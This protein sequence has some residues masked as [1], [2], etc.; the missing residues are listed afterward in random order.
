MEP[1]CWWNWEWLHITLGSNIWFMCRCSNVQGSIKLGRQD[2]ECDGGCESSGHCPL[3]Q[4]TYR[5]FEIS[6]SGFEVF[7]DGFR[8]L[9]AVVS[10]TDY[11]LRS[12]NW[13]LS[14]WKRFFIRHR[15]WFYIFPFSL[16]IS[17]RF[18]T[19]SIYKFG[20][21]LPQLQRKNEFKLS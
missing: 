18:I 12:L 8:V 14:I 6:E 19:F 2:A 20:P 10:H 21:L 1:T 16:L 17:F 15:A 5:Y 4:K 7:W 11:L 3:P 9:V 13:Q